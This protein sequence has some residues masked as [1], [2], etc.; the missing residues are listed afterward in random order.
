MLRPS[1]G[2]GVFVYQ[3]RDA[4]PGEPYE[5]QFTVNAPSNPGELLGFSDTR[6]GSVE[7]ESGVDWTPGSDAEEEAQNAGAALQAEF[8]AQLG[9]GLLAVSV[10][11]NVI[12]VSPVASGDITNFGLGQPVPATYDLAATSGGQDPIPGGPFDLPVGR[13]EGLESGQVLI[14]TARIQIFQSAGIITPSDFNI[15]PPPNQ[16]RGAA[17]GRVQQSSSGTIL[18]YPLN[19]TSGA[20][21]EVAVLLSSV[22]AIS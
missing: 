11:A 15:S 4:D 2:A 10:F 20:G 3:E 13:I 9:A 18:G 6:Y 14:S 19:Q 21:E 1:E 17:D 16:V 5:I 12:T 22:I 7:L 8:D